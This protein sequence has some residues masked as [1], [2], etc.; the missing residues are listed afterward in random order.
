MKHRTVETTPLRDDTITIRIEKPV[1]RKRFAPPVR[2]HGKR[3]YNRK[4]FKA[5]DYEC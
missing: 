2:V 4:D 5:F 3:G 1:I